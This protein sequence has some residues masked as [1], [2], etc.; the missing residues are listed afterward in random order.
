MK[1]HLPSFTLFIALSLILFQACDE[2]F[3]IDDE[4]TQSPTGSIL[5]F[6]ETTIRGRI[7]DEEGFAVSNATISAGTNGTISD[8][9]GFFT[10][11]NIDA[12]STGLY[13]KV[14]APNFHTGGDHF[15]P[16]EISTYSTVLRLVE[17][18]I[19]PSMQQKE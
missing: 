16:I 5:E 10:L 2:D 17:K 3:I 14:E 6:Y 18:E 1:N 11:P 8:Q 9:N 13:I 4:M 15:Y 7:V 12:P 19:T